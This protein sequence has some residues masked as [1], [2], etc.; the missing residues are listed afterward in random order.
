V[1]YYGGGFGV[2]DQGIYPYCGTVFELSPPKTKGGVWTEKVLYSFKSGTDGANPNGNLVF[3]KKGAIYGTTFF[4]GNQGCK[5]D[6]GVG[7]GTVFKLSPPAKTR[8][9]WGY[10]VLHR[11]NNG[12]GEGGENPAAGVVLD[13]KGTIYGTTLAGGAD[14]GRH[15]LRLDPADKTRWALERSAPS[16]V[17]NQL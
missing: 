15:C 9:A 11:F 10:E 4:G 6:A 2:C 7:C 16:R 13:T 1:T 3:D 5:Q 8:H 14:R 12:V 17:W